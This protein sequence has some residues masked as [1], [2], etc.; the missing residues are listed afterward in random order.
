MSSTAQIS[1]HMQSDDCHHGL[2]QV[3]LLGQPPRGL[4]LDEIDDLLRLIEPMLV[5]HA[6]NS[7]GLRDVHRLGQM[8]TADNGCVEKRSLT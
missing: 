1:F 7:L 8:G 6:N 2:V 4:V 3:E 5:E